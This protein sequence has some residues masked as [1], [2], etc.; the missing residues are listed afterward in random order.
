MSNQYIHPISEVVEGVKV[1]D[2]TYAKYVPGY[3]QCATC[4]QYP[5][6][7]FDSARPGVVTVITCDHVLLKKTVSED[8]VIEVQVADENRKLKEKEDQNKKG[9]NG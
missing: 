6:F 5:S 7:Q 1:G 4:G 9:K 2:H 3:E 8:K